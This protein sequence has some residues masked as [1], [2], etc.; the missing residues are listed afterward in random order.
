MKK[1]LILIVS[2]LMFA[3]INQGKSQNPECEGDPCVNLANCATWVVPAPLV[4]IPDPSCPSCTI[5]VYYEER[6]NSGCQ[7]ICPGVP[8]YE[9]RIDFVVT[10]GACF[11][12]CNGNPPLYNFNDTEKLYM[13][14][15][16]ELT[17]SKSQGLMSGNCGPIFRNYFLSSCKKQYVSPS[18]QV[19][20]LDCE[21]FECCIQ[22][23][24]YC[25]NG[26]GESLIQSNIVVPPN[27]CEPG[28][29]GLECQFSCLWEWEDS[30]IPKRAKINE[31]PINDVELYLEK[32]SGGIN[33]RLLG[34]LE[35]NLTV[36]VFN[37]AAKTISN[38]KYSVNSS[39]FEDKVNGL[40]S[41]A[42]YIAFEL[43]GQ[44]IKMD[45]FLITE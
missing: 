21:G 17:K 20:I 2:L 4:V 22:H 11:Y 45:K 39:Q 41:G 8:L 37:S 7:N 38:E 1:Y 15:L 16:F 14:G 30:Y 18:G 6:D 19:Y 26:S 24:Q 43:N 5:T 33:Y 31:L 27:D 13:I 42:Y 3:T 28:P 44:I 36:T 25:N 10:N 32:S 34:Q 12:P 29:D 35:G 9:F 23:L 40:I